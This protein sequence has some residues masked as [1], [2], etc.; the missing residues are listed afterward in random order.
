[1]EKEEQF[2]NYLVSLKNDSNNELI[3]AITEGFAEISGLALIESQEIHISSSEGE[4]KDAEIDDESVTNNQH[5]DDID[6]D[7]DEQ[8][9]I[10]KS[11]YGAIK[12]LYTNITGKEFSTEEFDIADNAILE[13]GIND[14][15]LQY[16][17]DLIRMQYKKN[18]KNHILIK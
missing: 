3:S 4:I 16:L 12:S 15:K 8:V 13:N 6:A 10:L 1:M 2:A 9:V 7:V 18:A 11:I 5:S 17:M 14:D